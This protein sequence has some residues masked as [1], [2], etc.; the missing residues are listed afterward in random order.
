MAIDLSGV[1]PAHL[2]PFDEAGESFL[3]EPLRDHVRSLDRHDG[4]DAM[5][6]NGHG[7]EVFALAPDERVRLVEIVADAVAT[8]TPVVSGLVAGSTSEAIREGQ[9]LCDAGADALLV[10]PPHTS[11]NHRRETATGYVEAIGDAVDVPLVVFQ[12][13]VWGGGTYD[14]DLLVELATLDA[15]VAIKNACWDMDRFQDDVHALEEAAVDTQLLVANDEHLLASY[16]VRTDGT[17]LILAAVIPDLI[18]DLHEAIQSGDL[19]AAR[20]AYRA[21][22]PLIRLA[23]GDPVADSTARLKK[24]LELRGIFPN[25]VPRP[26]AL[27]VREDEVD[28]IHQVMERA[29]LSIPPTRA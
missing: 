1:H 21:A 13:P 8:S 9:R 23:F 12:H 20:R 19:A 22:D 28:D 5:V 6:T 26:P 10:F 15:V 29:G 16:A 18:V 11:I 7:A 14:S 4:I 2:V 27:P 3:E 25:A 17:I 24:M